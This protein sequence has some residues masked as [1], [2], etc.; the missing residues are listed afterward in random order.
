MSQNKHKSCYKSIVIETT[1][2]WII[3]LIFLDQ[4]LEGKNLLGREKEMQIVNE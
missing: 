2:T 4:M 1:I 3:Q